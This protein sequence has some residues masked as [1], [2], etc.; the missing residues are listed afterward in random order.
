MLSFGDPAGLVSRI[1]AAGALAIC[2]VQSLA[3]AQQ[4]LAAGPT[5]WWRR[6]PRAVAHGGSRSL[7]TLLP[8]IVD[9]AGGT[10]PVVAAGGIADG[11]GGGGPDARGQ[12]RLV[13]TRFYA[14]EEA[15]S[16]A[17]KGASA[18]RRGDDTVRSI[19]FDISRRNVWPEPFTGRCLRNTHTQRWLGREVELMQNAQ[20]EAER[21]ARAREAG[22]FDVA[23]VIAGEAIGLIRVL[24]AATIV[25]GLVAEAQ[26]PAGGRLEDGHALVASPESVPGS[27]GEH[28][29]V[30]SPDRQDEVAARPSREMPIQ[31]RTMEPGSMTKPGITAA[32]PRGA[33]RLAGCRPAHCHRRKPK[34]FQPRQT[35]RGQQ[36][37]DRKHRRGVDRQRGECQ[38]QR[39]PGGVAAAD[40]SPERSTGTSI[41]P[42]PCAVD[43]AKPERQSRMPRRRARRPGVRRDRCP[44]RRARYDPSDRVCSQ[45]RSMAS[46]RPRCR[47]PARRMQGARRR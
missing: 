37:G 20:V 40:A 47:P 29:P 24:P 45:P 16:P 10:T 21:Y 26:A 30:R 8:E 33:A 44:A 31:T 9:A 2:Q 36:A 17:A 3:S 41:S 23:A 19:V 14:T 7:F 4:A 42:A 25:Q 22:D 12:R 43:M 11:R 5:C 28:R 34:A 39:I 13:G 46:R 32:A 1:H 6:A 15:A 35:P 27:P 18:A 38:A